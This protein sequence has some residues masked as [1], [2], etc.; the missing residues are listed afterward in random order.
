VAVAFILWS[1]YSLSSGRIDVNFAVMHGIEVFIA[2]LVRGNLSERFAFEII[3][4]FP[5]LFG[6][7]LAGVKV[8]SSVTERKEIIKNVLLS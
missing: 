7:I 4:G 2:W 8:N 1:F 5:A 3:L 6:A